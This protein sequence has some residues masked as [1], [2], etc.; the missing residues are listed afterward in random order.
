[1]K[2]VHRGIPQHK[3]LKTVAFQ[4]TYWVINS[5]TYQKLK[6]TC[7]L[8]QKNKKYYKVMYGEK[9]MHMFTA[10]FTRYTNVFLWSEMD[11]KFWVVT[12]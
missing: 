9:V 3:I 12:I 10:R 8:A 6:K 7:V 1:M 5:S 4:A 11:G 2:N